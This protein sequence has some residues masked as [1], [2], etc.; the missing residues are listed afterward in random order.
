MLAIVAAGTIAAAGASVSS[1][2]VLLLLAGLVVAVVVLRHPDLAVPVAVFLLWTNAPVVAAHSHGAPSAV[3]LAIPL[4]LALP[5]MARIWRGERALVMTPGV[6][7]MLLLLLV[8]AITTITSATTSA[9]LHQIENFIIEGLIVYVLVVNVV[10]TPVALERALWAIVA[11]AA[12][13]SALTVFQAVTGRSSQPMLGFAGLDHS[14]LSGHGSSP[15]SNGPVDDPNYYAQLLLPP[16]A[17]AVMF[18]RRAVTRRLRLFAAGCGLLITLG[19]V[20]TYSRGGAIALA[21]IVLAYLLFGYLRAGHV[22]ALVLCAVAILVAV[23]EYGSRLASLGGLSGAGAQVGAS[24]AADESALARATEN[25][26]AMLAF[27]DHPLVGVGPGNFPDTYQYYAQKIGNAVHQAAKTASA[28]EAAG[29]APAR[30]AHSLPLGIAADQGVI[31]LLVF[32]AFVLVTF[33]ELLAARR[34]CRS[35]PRLEGMAT[36]LFVG[37][38]GY[39]VAGAFLSLAF[40]RYLWL[41][42]ALA[43]AAIGILR[44]E[45]KDDIRWSTMRAASG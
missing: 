1:P 37:L 9:S 43:G 12:W 39:L 17:F 4:L 22:A 14:F 6:V 34:R 42:I 41:L 28:G 45:R 5:L 2:L 33:A 21:A 32:A 31:G 20:F 29:E 10:R 23:P 15:R 26:A 36:A 44:H 24:G 18:A 40:E 11:A 16:I 8:L 13:L 27:A 7:W 19:V 35:R 30:A 3:A 25:K 38:L